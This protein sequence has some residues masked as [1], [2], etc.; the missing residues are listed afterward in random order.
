MTTIAVSMV[1][2]E[3]DVI[4]A[5][6]TNMIHQV[7]H[8]IIADNRSTDGTRDILDRLDV[9]V[10]DDPEP[11]YYQSRKVTTLARLARDRGAEWVV[12][13]DADEL[14]YSPHGR[15]ADALRNIPAGVNVVAARVFDHVATA[16][17]GPGPDPVARQGWRNRG[18]LELPKVACRPT[19][20]LVIRQGNHGADYDDEP[21][22]LNDGSLIVRHF[23]YRSVEQ[24]IRKV[25]N[26]AEAYRAAEGLRSDVGVHW[27]QWGA[28]LDA[29]GEAA[30]EAIFRTWYYRDDPEQGERRDGELL[31]PLVWDPAPALRGPVGDA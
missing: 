29:Q 19:V 22:V 27:R 9:E 11:G 28:I 6:V 26:G 31:L 16:K 15:I 10:I 13:F 18:W 25:R 7:D 8:V 12:P 14:W 17:D 24:F 30:V 1:R 4:E 23:P 3:A 2:D 21:R 5:T 20:D